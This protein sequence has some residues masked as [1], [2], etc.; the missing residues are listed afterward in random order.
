MGIFPEEHEANVDLYRRQAT[1]ILQRL[2]SVSQCYAD[3]FGALQALEVRGDSH[4]PLVT[5]STTFYAMKDMSQ[6]RLSKLREFM[7]EFSSGIENLAELD[8]EKLR[9]LSGRLAGLG[10][11]V[12]YDTGDRLQNLRNAINTLK[13]DMTGLSERLLDSPEVGNAQPDN[14]PSGVALSALQSLRQ[15]HI[16]MWEN[17]KEYQKRIRV[18]FANQSAED[19]AQNARILSEGPDLLERAT[20]LLANP[21]LLDAQK[22]QNILQGIVRGTA[23]PH[24]RS[25]PII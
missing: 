13:S 3:F 21:E 6:N 20:T 2:Q 18:L 11:K 15:S 4:A 10:Y 24:E 17:I 19:V 12:V 23:A 8:E 25:G 7:E 9:I 16:P 1:E 5:L 22:T 14:G